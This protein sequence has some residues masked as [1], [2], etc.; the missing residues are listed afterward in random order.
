MAIQTSVQ[1]AAEFVNADPENPIAVRDALKTC[2]A[3]WEIAAKNEGGKINRQKREAAARGLKQVAEWVNAVEITA[4]LAE[5][6]STALRPSDPAYLKLVQRKLAERIEKLPAGDERELLSLRLQALQRAEPPK[7]ATR[8]TISA[9]STVQL[10]SNAPAAFRPVV[11]VTEKIPQEPAPARAT[12]RAAQATPTAVISPRPS[13][14]LNLTLHGNASF[15]LKLVGRPQLSIGRRAIRGPS[16]EFDLPHDKPGMNAVSRRHVLFRESAGTIYVHDGDAKNGADNGTSWD[17]AALT[18]AGLS[19]DLG[20]T[21]R[22]CLANILTFEVFYSPCHSLVPPIS[23]SFEDSEGTVVIPKLTG[24][25]WIKPSREQNILEQSAAWLFTDVKVSIRKDGCILPSRGGEP[26]HFRFYY[27]RNTF[28]IEALP[29][30]RPARVAATKLETGAAVP[31][32]T[33]PLR[34]GEHDYA[35]TISH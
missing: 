27:F 25:L 22:L 13:T 4:E 32:S 3:D 18:T 8:E 33:G 19:V 24:A 12:Q 23:P 34:L 10:A 1:L 17:N 16:V 29:T 5:L 15:G 7:V 30:A 20:K 28:W 21:H 9:K 11:N 2:I 26:A 35:I 6:S 14:L 31:L